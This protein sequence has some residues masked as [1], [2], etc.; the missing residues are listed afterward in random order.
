[1]KLNKGYLLIIAALLFAAN[2]MNCRNQ[3]PVKVSVEQR[4]LDV[5]VSC[6]AEGIRDQDDMCIWVN[7]D[8]GAWL[9]A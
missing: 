2:F 6:A 1:V 4:P 8:D 9:G 7:L 3:M 5:A